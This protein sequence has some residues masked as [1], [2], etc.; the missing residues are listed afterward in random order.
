MRKL[1]VK[2]GELN[3]KAGVISKIENTK[4]HLAKPFGTVEIAIDKVGFVFDG[5]KV[6]I[7]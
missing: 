5:R 6:V 1:A 7:E 4:N 3:I 2:R